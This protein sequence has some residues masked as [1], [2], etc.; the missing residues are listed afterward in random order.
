MKLAVR[1]D[2]S[3]SEVRRLCGAPDVLPIYE[4]LA[5]CLEERLVR[6]VAGLDP[7]RAKPPPGAPGRTPRSKGRPR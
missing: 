4:V 3:P 5:R 2:C 6:I 1:I 7:G